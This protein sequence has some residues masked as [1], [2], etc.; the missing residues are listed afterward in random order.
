MSYANLWFVYTIVHAWKTCTKYC[1]TCWHNTAL[2]VLLST[3]SHTTTYWDLMLNPKPLTLFAWKEWQYYKSSKQCA[4]ACPLRSNTIGIWDMVSWGQ[5]HNVNS[6]MTRFNTLQF[7]YIY[8]FHP[9]INKEILSYSIKIVETM[10]VA[11][12]NV[13]SLRITA[14]QE[15]H[16]LKEISIVNTVSTFISYAVFTIFKSYEYILFF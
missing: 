12:D 15:P 5:L 2:W 11:N 4:T 8:F 10:T 9:D 6:D 1:I 13:Y 16:T 7:S 3:S 14:F